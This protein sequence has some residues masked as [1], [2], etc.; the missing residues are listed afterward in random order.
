VLTGLGNPDGN[1][2]NH[3]IGICLPQFVV[4]VTSSCLLTVRSKY[5]ATAHVSLLSVGREPAT[6][7]TVIPL[8]S[9]RPAQIADA[10]NNHMGY[11]YLEPRRCPQTYAMRIKGAKL[12]ASGAASGLGVP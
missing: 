7:D 1:R 5:A 11:Y 6:G 9:H 4:N 3:E 12:L 8:A 10:V 2:A